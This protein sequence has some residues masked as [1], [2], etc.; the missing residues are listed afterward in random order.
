MDIE[1]NDVLVM[2]KAHPC[3]SQKLCVL[4][5]GADFKLKCLNCGREFM[6]PRTKIERKIKR[7]E[8]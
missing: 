4:R 3:G 8:K 1:V 6:T 7:I 2:K 5:A